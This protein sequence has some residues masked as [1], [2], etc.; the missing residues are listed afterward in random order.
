MRREDG[1]GRV[2]KLE[3]LNLYG[4]SCGDQ[5]HLGN[6]SRGHKLSSKQYQLFVEACK[7]VRTHLQF[8]LC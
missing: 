4:G 8:L 1:K 6:W 3:L 5:S 7:G 2:C